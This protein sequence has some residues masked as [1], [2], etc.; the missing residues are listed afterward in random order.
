MLEIAEKLQKNEKLTYLEKKM[1]REQ[2]NVKKN[3]VRLKPKII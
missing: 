2:K 1:T 3:G